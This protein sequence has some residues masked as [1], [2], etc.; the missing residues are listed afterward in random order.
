MLGEELVSCL[1]SKNWLVR[2][3]ALKQLGRVAIGSLLLGVGEGRAGVV[4]SPDRQAT[5][6]QMLE[7]CCSILAYI[8]AD[9]VYKVFVATLVI[10]RFINLMTFHTIQNEISTDR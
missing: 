5:T 10:S 9:P 6:R 3:I 1:F 4:L 2:E 7:T 8:C